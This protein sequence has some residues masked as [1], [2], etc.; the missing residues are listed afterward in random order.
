[1]PKTWLAIVLAALIPISAVGAPPPNIV[2]I[3]ADDLGWTDLG[4]FRE[5]SLGRAGGGYYS[6]PNLD[7]LARDGMRFTAAYSNGPNCAPTRACLMSGRYSPRHGIYTVGDAARGK[8]E[9]RKLVPVANKTNL[10]L[11]EVTLGEAL[12]AA[13]YATA[14]AGKWHLGD[15]PAGGPRQHGFDVNIGGYKAG[16]PR[17]YFSPYRNPQLSDGPKGEYL[18]DRI[19][20]ESLKFIESQK[21]KPF[22]LYLAYYTVHT[23]LQAKTSL[24][25]I[26]DK[27]KPVGGHSNAKYAA[28]VHS[29]DE[30]IGRVLAKLEELD[31]AKNTLVV[32]TSD[33]GGVGGY[34]NLGGKNITSNA[35]LRGGKGMLYE[36]GIRVPLIARWPGVVKAGTTCDIPVISIDFY[37]TF[38]AA[39]GQLVDQDRLDG[40]SL[41]GI[42][43]NPNPRTAIFGRHVLY[44]H[45]PAYLQAN[46]KRGTWR[47]TPAGAVRMA[48][49][50]KLIEFFED[51]RLELYDLRKDIGEKEN[52][53]DKMPEKTEEL[54]GLLQGWRESMKAPMPKLRKRK[55]MPRA[56]KK[57]QP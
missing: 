20:T 27:K 54:L 35:P 23:P 45:F 5:L 38:L 11:A 55:P 29:L 32:F 40:R 48:G 53:A 52:L 51:G 25:A 47:T 50:Y 28:M 10:P 24:Q 22:F 37:P 17:S 34:G 43:R 49:G 16:H 31:L 30:N 56:R 7:R 3:L 26:Y 18:T 41:L 12:K 19:T 2:F 57:K 42:L 39:A 9:H 44:W 8:R 6:T 4:C 21:K 15:P 1:M 13:G 14:Y 46:V 36:G 33:N